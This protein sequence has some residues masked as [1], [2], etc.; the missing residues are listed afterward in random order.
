MTV[1]NSYGLFTGEL[2]GGGVV[3]R[4]ASIDGAGV[5]VSTF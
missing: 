3:A 4:N 5:F 1:S 2:E